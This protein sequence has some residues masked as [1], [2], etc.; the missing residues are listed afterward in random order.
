MTTHYLDF[1]LAPD[2]ETSATHLL[3][4]LYDRFHLALVQRRIDT[5][6]VSFP[7]YSLVPRTLG[8]Q[9]RLH[10]R[11]DDLTPFMHADWLKGVRDHVHLSDILE[12][13]VNAEHRAVQRRQ[14]KTSADRL[15][16]RRMRRKGETAAQAEQAIP[17]TVERRPDLPYVQLRSRS[18]G[19]PFSLFVALGPLMP[20]ATPGPFNAYGLSAT[21]TVPWF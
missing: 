20:I 10:G 17:V 7:G 19:Q 13:P 2:P 12:T 4:A 14:F 3:G 15:R 9:L 21:T 18:T 5:I 6:G 1:T 8:T 11:A 16:R